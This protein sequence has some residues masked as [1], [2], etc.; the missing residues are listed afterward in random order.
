MSA[1]EQ[2]S[3]QPPS[4][5]DLM[6]VLYGRQEARYMLRAYKRWGCGHCPNTTTHLILTPQPEAARWLGY[7]RGK[8]EHIKGRGWHVAICWKCYQTLLA[9][10]SWQGRQTE[11]AAD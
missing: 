10:Q 11:Q 9:A 8:Q 4:T 6:F 5:W 3:P 2:A 7:L 1:Q